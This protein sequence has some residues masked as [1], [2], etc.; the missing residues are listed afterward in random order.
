[1]NG[2]LIRAVKTQLGRNWKHMEDEQAIYFPQVCNGGAEIGVPGFTYNEDIIY[3]WRTNKKLIIKH[4]TEIANESREDPLVIIQN[5]NLIRG[6]FSTLEIAEALYGSH[7]DDF[8]AIYTVMVWFVLEEVAR[9]YC[10]K[11]GL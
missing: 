4:F 7:K 6:Q 5:I 11:K 2:I 9:E 1:M 8:V 10:D 3:F